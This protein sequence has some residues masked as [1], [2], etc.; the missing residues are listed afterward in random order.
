MICC[1]T[2]LGIPQRLSLRHA[3]RIP[4]ICPFFLSPHVV[5]SLVPAVDL[6]VVVVT[7]VGCF[8][9]AF[10]AVRHGHDEI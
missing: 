9:I 4:P 1:C 2:F 8:A 5:F 6:V 7:R 3:S 10:R